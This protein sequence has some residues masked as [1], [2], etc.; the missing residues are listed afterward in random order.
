MNVK[1]EVFSLG[2]LCLLFAQPLA[3]EASSVDASGLKGTTK[4]RV[5]GGAAGSKPKEKVMSVAFAI[6]PVAEGKPAYQQAVF[7]TSND[8]GSYAVSL[9]PGKYWVGPPAKA[10]APENYMPGAVAVVEQIVVVQ[11]Q[12]WTHL[13]VL[14]IGN[15]P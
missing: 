14:E 15:A 3:V 6:A 4:L 1:M 5:S 8:D 2:F 12:A 10:R 13:D 9:T 11:E 7:V